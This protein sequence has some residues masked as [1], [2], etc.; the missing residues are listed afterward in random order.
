MNIGLYSSKILENKLDFKI[1]KKNLGKICPIKFKN[2]L[3]IIDKRPSGTKLTFS[4]GIMKYIY[5][6]ISFNRSVKVAS[7]KT[8]SLQIPFNSKFKFGS[9]FKQ[10]KVLFLKLKTYV[11]GSSKKNSRRN[12]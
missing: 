4:E 8:K 7:Y 9:N 6:I 5:E 11:L 10:F 2:E 1:S 3:C 12:D